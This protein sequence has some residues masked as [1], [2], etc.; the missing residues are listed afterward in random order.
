MRNMV[1]LARIKGLI[2]A[3]YPGAIIVKIVNLENLSDMV[4]FMQ[5]IYFK[6]IENKKLTDAI[7]ERFGSMSFEQIAKDL[8]RRIDYTR[9]PR[10]LEIF[11][12]AWEKILGTARLKWDC[13]DAALVMAI[14]LS[15]VY[16]QS[17]LAFQFT[18]HHAGKQIHHVYLRFEDPSGKKHL[19]DLVRKDSKKRPVF[20][21]MIAHLKTK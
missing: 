3:N 18:S 6:A 12:L 19:I 9:E 10:G 17:P 2:K 1:Q 11:N 7:R 5:K 4:L 20:K 15:V 8:R 16:P 13:D 14:I 21:K